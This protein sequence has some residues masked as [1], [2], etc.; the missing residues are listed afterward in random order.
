MTITTPLTGTQSE[1]SPGDPARP[2]LR[3][4]DTEDIETLKGVLADAF[5]DDPVFDWLMPDDETRRARLRRFFAIELEHVG[6]ARGRVWI[7]EDLTGA[8]ISLP[9]G[10]WR[11]PAR[12]MLL[13]S[14]LFGVHLSR[15][16]RL[17]PRMEWHHIRKP[18]YYFPYIGVAPEAQGNGLG[19]KLMGVTLERCDREGLPAYL[20][21]SS[22]RSAVLYERLGFELLRELRVGDSPPLQLMLRRPGRLE[23]GS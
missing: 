6:V 7:P 22:D 20:E 2:S 15:A 16:A 5:Y 1:R 14:A 13:Q 10:S 11:V 9:P 12:A 3:R 8:V 4:A 21:A 19:G 18:H 17:L 23:G